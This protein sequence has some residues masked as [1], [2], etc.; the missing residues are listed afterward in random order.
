MLETIQSSPINEDRRRGFKDT[1]HTDLDGRL[2]KVVV[3]EALPNESP[4][5]PIISFFK[6]NLKRKLT[7]LPLLF[8]HRVED[9]RHQQKGHQGPSP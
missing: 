1:V 7:L 2:I 9:L 5:Y 6:V 8:M 4:L 3:L